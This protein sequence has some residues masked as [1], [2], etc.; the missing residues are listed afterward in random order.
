M[1]EK[2][3]ELK[4]NDHDHE[5]SSLKHRVKDVEDQSKAINKLA[6]SVEKLALSVTYMSEEQKNSIKRLEALESKPG[7]RWEQIVT[8]CITTIVGAIIGFILSRSGL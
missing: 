8:I 1:D 6:L 3:I 7:K 5:I 4:L 2:D